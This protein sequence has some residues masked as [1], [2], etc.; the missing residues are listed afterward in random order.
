M[1]IICLQWLPITLRINFVFL[2]V[3][4]Q[5]LDDL[6]LPTFLYFTCATPSCSLC[7][8][9]IP[10]FLS[11]SMPCSPCLWAFVLTRPSARNVLFESPKAY[12]FMSLRTQFKAHLPKETVPDHCNPKQ[13]PQPQWSFYHLSPFVFF[14]ALIVI[15]YLL[16][17]FPLHCLNAS[18]RM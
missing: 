13:R 16:Y 17:L 1:L 15:K 2:S 5:R 14:I 11:L 10:F 4:Y 12:P 18:P 9:D 7:S 8:S 3:T 6:P